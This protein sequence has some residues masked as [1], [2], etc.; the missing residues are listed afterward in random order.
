MAV[1]GCPRDNKSS[2]WSPYNPLHNQIFKVADNRWNQRKMHC[3]SMSGYITKFT[4]SLLYNTFTQL[5]STVAGTL[6]PAPSSTAKSKREYMPI[7]ERQGEWIELRTVGESLA[8]DLATL[9]ADIGTNRPVISGLTGL[10]DVMN[11]LKGFGNLFEAVVVDGIASSPIGG[12]IAAATFLGILGFGIDAAFR[13]L[14]HIIHSGGN[15]GIATSKAGSQGQGNGGTGATP[16]VSTAA[17]SGTFIASILT[18][19]ETSQAEFDSLLQ[20]LKRIAVE[21]LDIFDDDVLLQIIIANMNNDQMSTIAKQNMVDVVVPD[22]IGSIE[23][24]SMNLNTSQ[25]EKRFG[26]GPNTRSTPNAPDPI[27]LLSQGQEDQHSSYYY[28]SFDPSTTIYMLE[29]GFSPNFPLFR[30]PNLPVTVRSL[31]DHRSVQG[32]DL[33]HGMMIA[34]FTVSGPWGTSPG[35]ELVV[36]P[37]NGDDG[38]HGLIAAL[39]EIV[40][41]ARQKGLSGKAVVNISMHIPPAPDATQEQWSGLFELLIRT[42]RV[43]WSMGIV[44]ICSAG[45]SGVHTPRLPQDIAPGNPQLL[46]VGSIDIR[47]NLKSDFS[48]EQ[49][50]WSMVYAPGQGFRLPQ[51]LIGNMNPGTSG[52]TALVSGVAATLIETSDFLQYCQSAIPPLQIGNIPRC[53]TGYLQSL[54]YARAPDGPSVVWN[55]YLSAS[56]S[57]IQGRDTGSKGTC[58]QVSAAGPTTTLPHPSATSSP[59]LTTS[60]SLQT[61]SLSSA[62]SPSSSPSLA[63]SLSSASSPSSSPSL[64]SSPSLTSSPSLAPSS[65]TVTFHPPQTVTSNGMICVLPYGSNQPVCT[66]L[67]TPTPNPHGTNVTV[68]SGCILINSSPRCRSNIGAISNIYQSFYNVASDPSN[69]YSTTLILS[70]YDSSDPYSPQQSAKCE[71]QARWPANYGDVYFGADGCLYDS[72]SNKI[73]NQCCSTPDINNSGPTVNPYFDPRPAASCQRSPGFGF[74]HFE[75]YSKGWIT[76][77]GDALHKQAKGCGL[78]TGWSFGTNTN[79]QSDG[80]SADIGRYR[81]QYLAK[82]NLPATF[83]SGCVGRAIASAGGPKGVDC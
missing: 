61:S 76:D 11:F 53:M 36:S 67:S 51:N 56:C 33:N 52:A 72:N 43:L 64:A 19:E 27:R 75:I 39:R 37:V 26:P 34:L 74:V 24:D 31:P 69:P 1:F 58:P 63:S 47:T 70:G 5:L 78:M 12:A 17:P 46:V 62:S 7:A 59:S 55:G 23:F 14:G 21:T 65:S 9:S 16:T 38:I 20:Y 49:P 73:F 80:S 6:A 44:T 57:G 30:P 3:N 28:P 13:S 32:T 8:R 79:I 71:L 18:K 50:L 66:P 4:N 48:I 45:N 77:N 15:P 22:Y 42:F 81:P 41:D 83:K 54:A 29:T 68:N 40:T 82:F 10:G 60:T 25:N 35:A 2:D